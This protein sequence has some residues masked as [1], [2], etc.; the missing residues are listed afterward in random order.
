MCE[1]FRKVAKVL[2]TKYVTC[3]WNLTVQSTEYSAVQYST[4]KLSNSAQLYNTSFKGLVNRFVCIFNRYGL[5]CST[6]NQQISFIKCSV[7]GS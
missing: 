6:I 3:K 7:N 5:S 1:C 4:F 2:Q